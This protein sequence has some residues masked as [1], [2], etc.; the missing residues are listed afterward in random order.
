[1][2]SCKCCSWETMNLTVSPGTSHHQPP[3]Q[4][5][6]PLEVVFPPPS[7]SSPPPPQKWFWDEKKKR[8]LWWQKNFLIL[9]GPTTAT[10]SYTHTQHFG[11]FLE[12][13][14][15]LR[16][17]REAFFILFQKKFIYFRFHFLFSSPKMILKRFLHSF[18]I[19][20]RLFSRFP[21]ENKNF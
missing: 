10:P 7:S 20:F 3:K 14:D 19:L 18:A 8:L 1:M 2:M 6:A 13:M 17:V 11:L 5:K 15:E 12:G 21:N 9:F 16:G 4:L